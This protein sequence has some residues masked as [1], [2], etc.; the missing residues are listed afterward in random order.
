[1]WDTFDPDKEGGRGLKTL[2]YIARQ[3]GIDLPTLTLARGDFEGVAGGEDEGDAGPAAEE[4]VMSRL[5]RDYCLVIDGG[6]GRVFFEDHDPDLGRNVWVRMTTQDF[7]KFYSDTLVE[8]PGGK[9]LEAGKA[10]MASP[11]KRKYTG[12]VFRPNERERDTRD[13]KLNLWTGFA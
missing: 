2:E 6:R 3:K 13:G 8:M 11:K 5:L 1:R 9:L 4:T 12:I 7:E 10:W